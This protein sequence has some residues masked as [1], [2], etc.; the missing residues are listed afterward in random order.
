MECKERVKEVGF[1]LLELIGFLLPAFI[2]SFEIRFI[3]LYLF[4]IHITQTN[5]WYK[6]VKEESLS[7]AQ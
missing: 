5:R 1:L 6:H 2:P 4:L 7:K 3:V